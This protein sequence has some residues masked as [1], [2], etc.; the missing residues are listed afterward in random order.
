MNLSVRCEYGLRAVLE[1]AR[2]Y[3]SAKPVTVEQI[4]Q[5]RQIPPK[6]LIHI[7]LQLKRAGLVSSVRGAKGGYMLGRL[8]EGISL[9]DIIEVVD[10]PVLNP[11]PL[12]DSGSDDLRPAWQETAKR[13]RDALAETSVRTIMQKSER[14][15]MFYI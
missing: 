12:R 13:V 1:L 2:R 7:L 3:Q 5:A 15:P 4:A 10:G 8:P 14:N 11:L 6:F 9:L